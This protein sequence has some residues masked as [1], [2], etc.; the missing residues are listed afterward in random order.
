MVRRDQEDK[1]GGD[2]SREERIKDTKLLNNQYIKDI[3]NWKILAIGAGKV[4]MLHNRC[5]RFNFV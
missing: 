4:K 3:C 2:T 5:D 1:E